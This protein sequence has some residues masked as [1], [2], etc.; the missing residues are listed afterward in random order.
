MLVTQCWTPVNLVSV[1]S[2]RSG[3]TLIYV[4]ATPFTYKH[5]TSYKVGIINHIFLREPV[6]P[7]YSVVYA[8]SR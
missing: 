5:L 8:V 4:T 2:P 3:R 1:N 7:V 6:Y